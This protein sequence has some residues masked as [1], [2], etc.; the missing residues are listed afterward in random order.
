MGLAERV[1]QQFSQWVIGTHQY[2]GDQTVVL[3]REGLLAVCQVL[4]GDV[5]LVFDVLMDLSCVDYLTFGQAPASSPTLR[6][7][8]PLPY[9]M[10]PTPTTETWQRQAAQECRFEVVYHLYSLS[11]NHRLRLKVPVTEADP[12]VDSVTS[13]WQSANWFE[14]EVWDMFGIRF[15]GH[16]NLKRILMYESFQGHALRKDY[17]VNKRQPIIGP[18]N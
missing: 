2:R 5:A 13:L 12:V 11:L 10:T 3:K 15:T 14:R 6:T 7:P 18:V 4:R 17:P 1:Q 16:P 8:S 9:F